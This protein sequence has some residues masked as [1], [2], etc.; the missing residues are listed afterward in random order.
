VAINFFSNNIT[1]KLK[2]VRITKA[3]LKNV[4]TYYNKKV[5]E[6]NYIFT[7][8][9]EILDINTK[10]LNHS[11]LTDIITFPYTSNNIISADIYICIE[12][13]K[14]NAADFQQ[15]F[16]EELNRVM[17]HGVLHMVGFNDHTEKE[18]YDMRVAENFWLNNLNETLLNVK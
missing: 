7:N 13:V 11:Y 17:V 6:I 1:F 10:F 9:K 2:K 16:S 3:W 5:G 12:V 8:E 14:S 15:E 4:I 18:Q